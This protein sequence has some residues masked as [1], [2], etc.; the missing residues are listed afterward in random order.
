MRKA[1]GEAFLNRRIADWMYR[2]EWQPQPLRGQAAPAEVGDDLIEDGGSGLS[3]DLAQHLRRQGQRAV[4][5]IDEGE[6]RQLCAEPFRDVVFLCG[7]GD[8]SDPPLA[9]EAASVSLLHVVQALSHAAAAPRLWLVTMG[10][11]GVSGA[12]PIR[13][14]TAPLWGLARTLQLEVPG[15]NCVCVDL[16]PQPASQD[17]DALMSELSTASGEAQVGYRS[18]ERYVARLVRYRDTR[19]PEIAGPFRLQLAGY[20]SPDQ[21]RGMGGS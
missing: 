1:S 19:M 11:Q 13:L 4:L 3:E 12:D 6:V 14:A 8:D 17:I 15:L 5:A 18:G 20:G 2:V 16:P 7:A 10:S 9:A 21:I